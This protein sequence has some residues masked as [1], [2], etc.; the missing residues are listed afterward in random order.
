MIGNW[1]IRVKEKTK[2]YINSRYGALGT[3]KP[4]IE[5]FKKGPDPKLR[6]TPH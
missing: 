2:E 3:P 4:E 5:C 6:S 1:L